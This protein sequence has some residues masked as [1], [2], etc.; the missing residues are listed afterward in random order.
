MARSSGDGSPKPSSTSSSCATLSA[1]QWM[2][3]AM[4]CAPTSVSQQPRLPQWHGSPGRV[5]AQVADLA[6]V[7]A[8]ALQPDARR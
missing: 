7:P 1:G 4:A 6:G 8:G 3:S 2:A 5:E